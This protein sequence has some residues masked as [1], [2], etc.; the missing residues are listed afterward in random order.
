MRSPF[1][2][3]PEEY[4]GR[5]GHQGSCRTHGPRRLA[6]SRHAE[7]RIT[8]S[9]PSPKA[10]RA[11][12]LKACSAWSP[13]VVRSSVRLITHRLSTVGGP[14]VRPRRPTGLRRMCHRGPQRREA[15][16]PGSVRLGPPGGEI[17]A[18]SPTLPP[19]PPHP[20]PRLETLDQTPLGNGPGWQ[21]YK[22]ITLGLST[23]LDHELLH[24]S[25]RPGGASAASH[26][27]SVTPRSFEARA[28]SADGRLRTRE[29][30]RLSRP[31]P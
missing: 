2:R 5:A 8:A 12:C 26:E 30:G 28:L 19:R 31:E 25:R 11:R 1:P 6:A 10:S 29:L 21:V 16:A 23:V 22:S 7:V 4:R 20:A 9:P 17:C 27:G 18:A 24:T 14:A 15:L 13:V 3:R